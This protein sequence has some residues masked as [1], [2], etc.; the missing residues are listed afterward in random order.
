MFV[1]NGYLVNRRRKFNCFKWKRGKLCLTITFFQLIISLLLTLFAVYEETADPSERRNSVSKAIGGFDPMTNPIGKYLPHLRDH[2]MFSLLGLGLSS[3]NSSAT[4]LTSLGFNLLTFTFASSWALLWPNLV[5]SIHRKPFL[6]F[7]INSIVRST[8]YGLGVTLSLGSLQGK[9]SP[10]QC[11]ILS[12]IEVPIISLTDYVL[13]ELQVADK[14]KGLTVFT[15]SVYFGL[16]VS[17]IIC[18]YTRIICRKVQNRKSDREMIVLLGTIFTYLASTSSSSLGDEKY[19]V[20]LNTFI[21]VT[22]SCL[23]A[24]AVSSLLDSQDRF[25]IRH[26]R[27]GSAAGFVAMSIIGQYILHVYMVFVCGISVGALSIIMDTQVNPFL[28]NRLRIHDTHSIHAAY[29]FPALISGLSS[30]IFAYMADLSSYDCSLYQIFPARAPASNSSTMDHNSDKIQVLDQ[31]YSGIGRSADSQALYQLFGLIFILIISIVTGLI[32]GMI[33]IQSIFDPPKKIDL[34]QD[35]HYW[36]LSS[37]G[38]D[39]FATESLY[40]SDP[41]PEEMTSRNIRFS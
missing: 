28:F 21:A 18:R 19:Y 11:I 13:S 17:A 8:Y 2:M 32:T 5:T 36:V 37:E 35:G 10:V 33:L 4:M 23:S 7:G 25:S 22:A 12:V 41:S 40:E 3:A 15:F 26:V 31:I 39:T 30:S 14:S 29:G 6:S 9:L 34:F 24:F 38:E 20:A 16:S 27:I 1:N